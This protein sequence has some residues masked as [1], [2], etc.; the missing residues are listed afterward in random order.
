MKLSRTD[1]AWIIDLLHEYDNL[2]LAIKRGKHGSYSRDLLITESQ[3]K[4]FL[5]ED[6]FDKQENT[7]KETN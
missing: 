2:E 6:C 7:T 3:L 4:M 1:R 5:R